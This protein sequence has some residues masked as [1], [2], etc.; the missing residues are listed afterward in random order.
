MGLQI[1]IIVDGRTVPESDWG[2]YAVVQSSFEV[3]DNVGSLSP[4]ELAELGVR[5]Y[6]QA[7][8]GFFVERGYTIQSV[9]ISPSDHD[10]RTGGVNQKTRCATIGAGWSGS[11]DHDPAVHP[12]NVTIDLR[13]VTDA[14]SVYTV[15]TDHR[16]SGWTT[17]AEQ[18]VV[19]NG[20]CTISAT[21]SSDSAFVCWLCSNGSVSMEREHSFRVLQDQT[22]TA[23][24]QRLEPGTG[25]PGYRYPV[26][27][28]VDGGVGGS[29]SKSPNM[30]TFRYGESCTITATADEGYRFVCWTSTDGSVVT[31]ASHT[32]TVTKSITWT[33]HFVQVDEPE[34]HNVR[35]V[36]AEGRGSVSGGGTYRVGDS[37]TVS[38]VQRY[39]GGDGVRYEFDRW[40]CSDGRTIRSASVNGVMGRADIT[41]SAH[42]R[43]SP[44]SVQIARKSA[45]GAGWFTCDLNT[46]VTGCGTY[47][48]GDTCRLSATPA[49]GA[50]LILFYTVDKDGVVTRYADGS[51]E[52]EVKGDTEV[53]ALSLFEQAKF[54]YDV[55][56]ADATGTEVDADVSDV[57]LDGGFDAE[58]GAGIVHRPGDAFDVSATIKVDDK[59]FDM[60]SPWLKAYPPARDVVKVE[61]K[62]AASAHCEITGDCGFL[63]HPYA[64]F[65]NPDPYFMYGEYTVTAVYAT[66]TY[67]VSVSFRHYVSRTQRTLVFTGCLSSSGTTAT[68]ECGKTAKF[69]LRVSRAQGVSVGWKFLARD[70]L[71]DGVSVASGICMDG[72]V[73]TVDLETDSVDKGKDVG[74]VVVIW[75]DHDGKVLCNSSGQVVCNVNSIVE[76]R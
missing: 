15:T 38:A 55:R 64:E 29:V 70:V 62:S 47:W 3:D 24:F 12:T 36:V 42:Y 63:V 60:A 54:F 75:H 13:I 69:N 67:T 32:F 50:K 37:Y 48:K 61:V 52:F 49:P 39:E 10:W 28:A 22:W 23:L 11:Y 51:A 66:G 65:T 59:K 34:F 25:S 30:D 19:S 40:T 4:E 68:Y 6:V 73:D 43:K 27:L 53:Y 5:W 35:A 18:R 72:A 9:S 26:Y 41:Y 20:T 44:Y 57:E 45:T 2:R 56:R 17:P 1:R 74:V 21:P 8:A 14:T 7:S 46:T 31:K 76:S 58:G 16:G 71:K 33:A